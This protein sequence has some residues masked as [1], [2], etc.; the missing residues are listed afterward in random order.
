MLIVTGKEASSGSLL[1]LESSE[2]EVSATKKPY[3]AFDI[4]V[5]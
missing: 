5:M 1:S 4:Q 2:S 3:H